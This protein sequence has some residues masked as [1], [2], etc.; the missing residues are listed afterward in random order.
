MRVTRH[1][2]R[3]A[4]RPA[5]IRGFPPRCEVTPVTPLSPGVA[6]AETGRE[7]G[8]RA[9]GALPNSFHAEAQRR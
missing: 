8:A 1:A 6:P 4:R 5:E 9:A 7:G 3:A 2:A